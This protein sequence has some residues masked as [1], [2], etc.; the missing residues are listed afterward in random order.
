MNAGQTN[1]PRSLAAQ[2]LL[3]ALSSARQAYELYPIGHPIRTNTAR[4]LTEM[5]SALREAKGGDP[6]LFVSDGNFYLGTTLLAWESLTLHRLAESFSEVGIRSLEFLPGVAE[7]DMD[8]LLCL[9]HGDSTR[10]DLTSIGINRA[11]AKLGG[12]PNPGLA[13]LL[14]S[15]AVGLE[16]LRGTAA[17]LLAGRPADMAA[18]VQLTEHLADLIA[19]DP[20]QALLLSTIKSYDEYTFHHMVNVCILS[21]AIARAIGLSHD[22]AISLGIA[23]LL[24]DI[25]KVKVPREILSHTGPLDEEQWRIIQRHPVEGAGLLLT[26]SRDPYHPAVAA[27]LE[28]HAAFDGSGYPELSESRSP[29]LAAR[30]VAV[31]DTFDAVTSTRSYRKAEERRQALSLL[32]AGAG[33]DFDPRVVRVFVRLMGLFPVG[34]LVQLSTGGVAVVVR[35]HDELLARPTVQLI[36]DA[37]GNAC[38]PVE[39][40]LAEHDRHGG[41][42]WN[43]VRS[44]DPA[45]VGIDMLT[46]IA[47]GRLDVLPAPAEPGLLHEPAPGEIPPPGYVSAH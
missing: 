42:R 1:E 26:T 9:L 46:L 29:S 14:Q 25:G 36:L 22:Q 13:G 39:V 23:G 17:H 30:I 15:Y 4:E 7:Q 27:I 44:I 24:H 35:G 8:G 40:D 43:V 33:R 28:H 45:D 31:A 2:Q 41:Y 20:G 10:S 6:V 38:E 34:S 12:D 47:S 5:V 18:T 32:Q 11:T 19:T 21:L 3:R 16:L 37:S